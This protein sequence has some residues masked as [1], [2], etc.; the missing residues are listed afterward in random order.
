MREIRVYVVDLGEYQGDKNV[1]SLGNL[2][3]MQEAERQGNVYSLRGFENDYNYDF[4][5]TS[6]SIIRFVEVEC[7]ESINFEEWAIPIVEEE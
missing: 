6:N 7:K 4:I 5:N 2:E 1:Y 3:F